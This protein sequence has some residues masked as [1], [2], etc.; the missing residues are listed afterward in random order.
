L[1]AATLAALGA[2]TS[3]SPLEVEIGADFVKRK[4]KFLRPIGKE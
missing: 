4:F 3:E 1:D 2:A